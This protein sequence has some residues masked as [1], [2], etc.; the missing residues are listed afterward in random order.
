[1]PSFT[2][3]DG[4]KLFYTDDGDGPV[5]L[6]LAGLTRN[7]QD[8]DHVLPHLTGRVLRLDYR[9]RGLSDWP[10]PEGYTVP[11]EAADALAL[12]D[13]LGIDRAAILGTS[14]GGIIAM[15]L[16]ATAKDRLTGV[17]LNDIGPDLVQEGLTDIL[18]YLGRDPVV[19]TYE[20]A[21]RGRAKALPGFANVP[22]S[23][24]MHDLKANFDQTDDGLKNRYD[25]QLRD[26]VLA[27]DFETP[28]DMW[29]LFDAMDGLPIALIRGAGSNL[30]SAETAQKMLERRPDMIFAEAP[31]R[32]HVPFLDEPESLVA[33]KQWQEALS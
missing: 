24:W 15:F 17:A 5:T 1:M 14:R 12:L 16:A 23:R 3:A 13:H 7:H 31:D 29:P 11:Q 8:F 19:P 6:C 27:A 10:G 2:T 22:E 30:L 20:L 9:G 4:C 28:P 33:L 18:H 26:A 32:G 21:L 25:N